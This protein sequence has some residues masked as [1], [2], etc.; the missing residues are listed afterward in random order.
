[1]KIVIIIIGVLLWLQV[2]PVL[3][4]LIE[5]IWPADFIKGADRV[6]V[7]AICGWVCDV[8]ILLGAVFVWLL[9]LYIER[10]RSNL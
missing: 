7:P 5:F 10:K 1:M 8:I 3:C 9:D 2:L 6:L 4:I